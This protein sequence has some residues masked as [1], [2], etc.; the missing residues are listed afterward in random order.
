MSGSNL[1]RYLTFQQLRDAYGIARSSA[2]RFIAEAGMPKPLQFGVNSVKFDRQ[3]IEEWLANRP[4]A[5][6]RVD[7]EA[8]A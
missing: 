8:A 2:Y 4:R 6:I 5:N 7:D 3:E 1:P